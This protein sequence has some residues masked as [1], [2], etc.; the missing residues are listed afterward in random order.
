MS[1]EEQEL[2]IELLNGTKLFAKS[3]EKELEKYRS[4]E[5]RWV[6]EIKEDKSFEYCDLAR[7]WVSLKE[8]E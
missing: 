8:Y 7:Y 2:V 6:V 3:E 4:L 1:T 5:A